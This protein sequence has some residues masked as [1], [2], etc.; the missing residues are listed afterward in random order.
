MV[1]STSTPTSAPS[2]SA[3][4]N[5]SG[6]AVVQHAARRDGR[7]RGELGAEAVRSRVRTRARQRGDPR[8]EPLSR[9]RP[10]HDRGPAARGGAKDHEGAEGRPHRA[11]RQTS[12]RPV[13]ERHGDHAQRVQA[14]PRHIGG[15]HQQHGVARAAH[16]PSSHDLGQ[17]RATGISHDHGPSAQTMAMQHQRSAY[18]PACCAAPRTASRTR[19]RDRWRSFD[20][21]TLDV[22]TGSDNSY[23]APSFQIARSTT[24]TRSLPTGGPRHL[25]SGQQRADAPSFE[26]AS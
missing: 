3:S 4:V 10:A 19:D 22:D 14:A 12:V 25:L 6:H 18:G 16:V 26:R 8:P 13:R 21:P 23:L 2:T 20:Q 15:H 9:A 1:G 11:G 24:G 7:E 17:R 5:G